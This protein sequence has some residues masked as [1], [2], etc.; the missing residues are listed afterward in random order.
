MFKIARV[1]LY[2]YANQ[3]VSLEEQ[4]AIT[5]FQMDLISWVATHPNPDEV[6]LSHEAQLLL[7]E[8]ESGAREASWFTWLSTRDADES[9]WEWVEFLVPEITVE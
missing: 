4:L 3:M 9:N 8:C 5:A 7:L 2:N 6:N 1:Q